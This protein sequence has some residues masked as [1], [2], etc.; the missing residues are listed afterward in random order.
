MPRT[1]TK[2]E[3]LTKEQSELVEKWVPLAYRYGRFYST[4]SKIPKDEA[5]QIAAE[6]LLRAA[7]K[8]DPKFECSFSTY[9]VYWIRSLF[10]RYRNRQIGLLTVPFRAVE[11]AHAVDNIRS[12]L[13]TEK[14]S[15]S[16]DEAYEK[17]RK[18]YKTKFCSKATTLAITE[19]QDK[20]WIDCMDPEFY[21]KDWMNF[22][23]TQ[24]EKELSKKERLNQIKEIMEKCLSPMARDIIC[25]RFFNNNDETLQSI[26]NKYN[27]S[28]ERI[29]QIEEQS[30][31]VI[32]SI[33]KLR[34]EI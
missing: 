27:L 25:L 1:E 20:F 26:G 18:T 12:S 31:R 3:P 34:G 19:M 10:L 14:G 29:R 13:K 32:R 15:A 2:K 16:F 4:K 6:G 17:Y 24:I 21:I 23:E 33:L 9:A 8:F 11:S 28:R 5:I 22:E 7:R 30:L